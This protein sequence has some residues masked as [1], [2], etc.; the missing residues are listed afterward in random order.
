MY[1]KTEKQLVVLVLR[2][3]EFDGSTSAIK[4]LKGHL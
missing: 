4:E 1:W 2:S 3:T